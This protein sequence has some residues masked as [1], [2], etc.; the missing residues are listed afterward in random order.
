MIRVVSPWTTDVNKY[1][2]PDVYGAP[3]GDGVITPTECRI[4]EEAGGNYSM[5]L[6]HPI[7]QE[8]R[9]ELIQPLSLICAPIPPTDTPELD[10]ASG[11]VIGVGSQV[12][13]V[14]NDDTNLYATWRYQYQTWVSGRGY[15]PG[16][17]VQWSGYVWEA[18]GYTYARPGSENSSWARRGLVRP[19]IKLM[20]AGT[21][22]ITDG[23]VQ[24]G[25]YYAVTLLDGTVGWV[26]TSMV[27]YMYTIEEG[28]EILEKI[29]AR[30]LT[31]Q[32][33]RVMDISLDGKS[34]TLTATCQHISYDWSASIIGKTSLKDTPLSTA[35]AAVRSAVLPD[36]VT[37]APFVYTEDTEHTVTAACTRKSLTSILLDPEDGLVAQAR[38]RLIR[39]EW[40]FFLLPDDETDRGYTIRYGVNLSGVSWRRDYTKLVTRA[41]PVAKDSNGDDYYLPERYVD[42][43]LR[44]VYPRD[45]YQAF[46]VDAK[47][48]DNDQTEE[49]VQAKMREEALKLYSEDEADRPVTTLTVDFLMLGDTEEFAQYKGLERLSLYDTVEVIHPDLGLRTRA[50]VKSYEWDALKKRYTKITLGDA[51]EAARHTVY[52]YNVADGAITARKLTPEAIAEIRG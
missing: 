36:G 30:T 10:P 20:S 3:L 51:F 32:L 39:D 50:Q 18:T 33:F 43:D 13:S 41:M 42:S 31:H 52:G 47:I 1:S 49:D 22:V 19:V 4:T 12:W 8:G 28:S 2:N 24:E 38:A 29:G 5:S 34:M 16:A 25:R 7:D 46:T 48:G 9:W 11:Q 37:S 44:S 45:Y 27:E 6:K 35:V 23:V 21:Q 14:K 17:I 40:D 26:D 15:M